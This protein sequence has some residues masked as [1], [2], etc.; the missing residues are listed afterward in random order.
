MKINKIPNKKMYFII[1]LMTFLILSELIADDFEIVTL[2]NDAVPGTKTLVLLKW[3]EISGI[4]GVNIYRKTGLMESYSRNPV[5]ETPIAMLT[6]CDKI[7]ELI[8]SGSAEWLILENFPWRK[9]KS[10]S[11]ELLYYEPSSLIRPAGFDPCK[12]A[13]LDPSSVLWERIQFLARRFYTISAVLGQSFIDNNVNSG[14]QYWYEVRA[15][16][17]RSET[18]LASDVM[19]S[20]G[21]SV[22]LPA[23]A[24]I[25]TTAGDSEVLITWDNVENAFGYDVFRKVIP[26]GSPVKINDAPVMAVVT[27]DLEGDSLAATMGI[28]D[29]RRWDD[30]GF[31]TTHNVDGSPVS[32]PVNGTH[33]K[34]QV[35]ALDG[36]E[37]PGTASSFS[38]MVMP[39]DTTAPGLPGDLSV[40]AVGQTLKITWSKVT[41]D[42]LGRVEMDGISGYNIY[43]SETQSDTSPVKLNLA[44]LP[45]PGGTEVHFIDSDPAII[46][47]YGEKEYYYRIDC[48]D[49]HSNQGEMSS[50]ASGFVPDIYAPDP[51]VNTSAEGFQEYIRVFWELNTEPDIYSYEIY[52]SLCHLGEWMDP[53]QQEK[54]DISSGDFV[55]IG[56]ITHFEAIEIS[57]EYGMPYFDDYT[58]PAGS[59][60]CYAYWIKAR[61]ASQNLSGSWPYPDPGEKSLIVC[62]RLRDETP[63]PPPIITAVQAR[64]EAIYLEWIAAPSQ[65]LGAFHIYRSKKENTDFFWAGGITVEEPP[66]PPAVLTIPFAPTKPCSCDVIPLVAHEGM[67][68]GFF[69]DK[70]VDPKIIY[71]YKILSVD[72]NGN[73]SSLTESIPY[74]S[75]TYKISGPQQPVIS[76]VLSLSDS[77]GLNI[78]WAPLFDISEHLGYIVFRSSSQDGIFRQISP[79]LKNSVYNDKTVNKGVYYW[80]KV[81]SLDLDGR[82][83]VLSASYKAKFEE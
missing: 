45:Q 25:Q 79:I 41:K 9:P 24:N 65:D 47:H 49:I 75:F 38:A 29:F 11:D 58:V 8:K 33:Y 54:M 66:T 17:G 83:S 57:A 43:R 70:D 28:V 22:P 68:A 44:L 34:Y 60:L 36:L 32:G 42:K 23:P 35:I 82:P 69:Y 81:Q 61:D 67:N 37:Q 5:N 59:P 20:A 10:K 73:E 26:H 78:T 7:R 1:F 80:Y 55:L 62:Q 52:R 15:V 48:T 4:D 40:E 71:Y 53:R 39:E 56:E 2:T 50:T 18:V 6:D 12:L 19:V 16:S 74:S 76:S 21:I 30:T 46:S 31:P 27:Q 64:D 3:N 63:P 72:Q 77:C 13:E 51:P 14:S